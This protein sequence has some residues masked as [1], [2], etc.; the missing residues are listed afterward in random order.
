MV[1]T[2]G[3]PSSIVIFALAES[4]AAVIQRE[5]SRISLEVSVELQE[6]RQ[7]PARGLCS[8]QNQRAARNAAERSFS[9]TPH[10][11]PRESDA[12]VCSASLT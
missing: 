12:C 11:S 6:V 5:S 1:C 10:V 3:G 7:R 8:A 4:N 2:V 9:N